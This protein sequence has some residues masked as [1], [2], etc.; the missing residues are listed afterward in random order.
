MPGKVEIVNDCCRIEDLPR[1]TPLEELRICYLTKEWLTRENSAGKE[2][3]IAEKKFL[4]QIVFPYSL[5]T[6]NGT[7]LEIR[8][9]EKSGTTQ[10]IFDPKKEMAVLKWLTYIRRA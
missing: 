5:V 4:R 7:T 2:D 9:I 3:E 1:D 8:K 10:W 6:K